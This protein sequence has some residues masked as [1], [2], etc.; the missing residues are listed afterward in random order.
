MHSGSN[1]LIESEARRPCSN[2]R[3]E[4]GEKGASLSFLFHFLLK[5]SC[6]LE[7]CNSPVVGVL[8][9]IFIFL[10]FKHGKAAPIVSASPGGQLPDTRPGPQFVC[11]ERRGRECTQRAF[12]LAGL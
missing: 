3:Y 7:S 8:G 1:D 9:D 10:F 12:D 4:L 2:Q 5:N 11:R 6:P